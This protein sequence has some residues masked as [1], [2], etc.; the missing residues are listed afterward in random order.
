MVWFQSIVQEGL[1]C[2][3]LYT[4]MMQSMRCNRVIEKSA[5]HDLAGSATPRRCVGASVTHAM[6][7]EVDH[8]TEGGT[9]GWSNQ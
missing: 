6:N 8:D 7:N 1:T 9:A 2:R 3:L 5:V 4:Y